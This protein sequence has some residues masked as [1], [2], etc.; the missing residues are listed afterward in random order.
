MKRSIW[1]HQF[2]QQSEQTPQE[3]ANTLLPRGIT[4][5]YVKAMDSYNWMSIFYDHPLAPRSPAH[6][7]ELTAEFMAVGLELIPWVVPRAVAAE[8]EAH[9]W[10]ADRVIIDWEYQYDGFW[11]G[12]SSEAW[13]YFDALREA[14]NAGQ[15]IAVAPDPR[16]PGRDYGVSLIAGLSAYLP[17]NY[18]TSFQRPWQQVMESAQAGMPDLLLQPI[19]PA[20]GAPG[21]VVAANEWCAGLGVEAVSLWRMGTATAAELDAFG[22]RVP[23]EE[24]EEPDLVADCKIYKAALEKGVNRLQ[25]ELAK[26]T[27]S[28]K[29]AALSKPLIREIQS[30]L[31][32]AL[33]G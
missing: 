15:W 20:N 33:Q 31:Y 14:K 9:A 28:G 12:G 6:L 26:R 21:D 27:A 13:G 7:K 4:G 22:Q 17:Q 25:I 24:A 1:V 19:L 32:Q 30:E 8:A 11:K 10:C 5:V 3:Y 23:G 29:P 2:S 16:Q 18:W